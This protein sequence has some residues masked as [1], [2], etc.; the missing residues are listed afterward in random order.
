LLRLGIFILAF[1]VLL[2]GT[3]EARRSHASAKTGE[4]DARYAALILDPQTGEIF[5]SR[6][7]EAR[8]YPASLTKMM[9]LYILF[10]ELKAGRVSKNTKMK[11]SRYAAK[12]PQTNIGLKRGQRISVRS[13]IKALVVRSANDVAVVV[14]EHISGSIK[15]FAKRATNTAH[16]LGMRKTTFVNPHG[17]PDGR[18]ITSAGDMAKLAIALMRDFPKYYSYFATEKFSWKGSTYYTHNRVLTGYA[19]VDGIKTGYIRA[20][21]FNLVTSVKRGGRRLIGVILGGYKSSWRDAQ[22]KKLLSKTYRIIAKRGDIKSKRLYAKNLPLPRHDRKTIAP[23]KA[24]TKT[25][26][27]PARV[28]VASVSADR[29]IIKKSGIAL[30]KRVP[31]GRASSYTAKTADSKVKYVYAWGIQVGAFIN[32]TQAKK[33]V[34]TAIKLAPKVLSEHKAKIIDA[35]IS[36]SRVHR[37]RLENLSE[38]QARLACRTLINKNAPCFVYRAQNRNL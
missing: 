37:A 15:N 6:N 20:S 28:K 10:E 35:A 3:A 9:T 38:K 1:C 33:A 7:A 12:Q 14:A 13:A 29:G 2:S 25:I 17:L 26:S 32:K 4:R 21:G 23:A 8:R 24:K 30:P 31:F 36:G 34:V 11:V 5:H 18:Q 27:K 22:M 19:G 16:A